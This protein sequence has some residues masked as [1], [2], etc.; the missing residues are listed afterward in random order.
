MT[1]LFN[2]RVDNI[3]SIGFPLS[4]LEPVHGNGNMLNNTIT[5]G[6]D[7]KPLRFSANLG[8]TL[9]DG[10]DFA[11]DNEIEINMEMTSLTVMLSFLA[12]ILE[13]RFFSL[14]MK[15]LGEPSCWLAA[16]DTE[17]M[18]HHTNSS[19][20]LDYDFLV[21]RLELNVSCVKCT[22]PRF[23]ELL[24]SLY[25]PGSTEE[26]ATEFVQQTRVMLDNIL[27]SDFTQ[28]V[29]IKIVEEAGLTCPASPDYNPDSAVGDYWNK[30]ETYFG[31]QSTGRSDKMIWFNIANGI[32]AACLF[33][34]ASICWCIIKKQNRDWIRGLEDDKVTLLQFQDEQQIDKDSFIDNHTTSMFKSDQIPRRVRYMVPITIVIALGL[35]LTGHLALISYVNISAQIAGEPL[36]VHR[37]LEF[38]F[39]SSAL[40]TYSNGGNE[41]AILVLVFSGFWQYIKLIVSFVLWFTPP[42][43][44]SVARRGY[45][46][47]WF[48]ILTVL[49]IADV[50]MLLVATA[51]LLIYVGGP[52][53]EFYNGE[54]LYAMTVELVP[55]AG[56]YCILIAQRLNR[57]SSRF[58]LDFHRKI[59][60][61]ASEEYRDHG[62]FRV[63]DEEAAAFGGIEVSRSLSTTT[64]TLVDSNQTFEKATNNASKSGRLARSEFLV[65]G[66]GDI[67]VIGEDNES[68]VNS[69]P[70]QVFFDEN[71]ETE[72]SDSSSRQAACTCLCKESCLEKIERR[73]VLRGTIGVV[74]AIIAGVTLLIIGTTLAPSATIDMKR[75]LGIALDSGRTYEQTVSDFNVF[76][77]ICTV[78][79]ETRF[80][81]DNTEDYVGL[82]IL[83]FLVIL[84]SVAFP[85]IQAAAK[86]RTWLRERRNPSSQRR[87]HKSTK[88]SIPGFFNR[89][90]A[91]ECMEIYIT[92]F[93]LASWQLG[94]VVAYVIHLYCENMARLFD[95][96][97]YVG[98]VERTSA[99][100][101]E[102]QVTASSTVVIVTSSFILLVISFVMQAYS[103]YKEN[104]LMMEEL[105]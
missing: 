81:L 56:L 46:F 2:A 4:L 34:I 8:I 45:I 63:S 99:Q 87:E 55:S 96:L 103:Q 17:A 51:A 79:L 86:F 67:E 1:R 98:I 48:D 37:F 3:D 29:M 97:S 32:V 40:R 104:K 54:D 82:G 64:S 75:V 33:V 66:K 10:G 43:T 47:L 42:K 30:P 91:Y 62:K 31:Y 70:S 36:R 52:G 9:N 13:E 26:E 73:G 12:N 59:I 80:V 58:F 90:K 100:C 102:I 83:I 61:S 22:S 16:I 71:N 65:Y 69:I 72:S 20:L 57:V 39:F 94:A 105:H 53:E 28:N 68:W 24:Q 35:F 77:T 85:A 27:G 15:Y 23:D 41:M 7:S 76:R 49:S 44:I 95:A 21:E 84:T 50:F 18:I 93:C 38:S 5:V 14:P 88:K 92:A 89:L 25:S 60:N 101:F 19:T 11:M 78:L 74:F 6:V